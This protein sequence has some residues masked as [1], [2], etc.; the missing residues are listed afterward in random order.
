MASVQT[1][2]GSRD[3]GDLGTT[4]L[5]EHVF[6]RDRELEL[7]PARSEWSEA[8][9]IERAVTGFAALHALGVRTIVDLTVPGLGRDV[10][11]VSAV[12]RR[13]PV[14]LVAS[15]GFYI[16]SELPLYYQFHGPG[17]PI[18]SP[19]PLVE[20][21]VRDIEA[22]ID[23]TTIRAAMLKVVTDVAGMTDDVARVMT[24]AAVAHQQTGV[25]ITTHSHAASRNG[26]AQQAFLR[27]HGVPLERVIIG[28]S[29]DSEDLAYLRRL[30]DD[31]S[32]IGMDR[33]GM[34]HVLP[35]DRRARIV[36]ALLR[37]G[38]G[39]RMVL[40]HDA[41]WFSHVT[42]PSWRA[43]A[44]PRWHME[45]IPRRILPMLRD[46]GASEADLH[47]MLVLNPSRLLEPSTHGAG[48]APASPVPEDHDH[49]RE[50]AT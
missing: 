10:R 30:M 48:A 50:V 17:R 26:L 25:P 40:S 21:F 32:T 42:P 18:D 13:V 45:N 39:D 47:Q 29:G 27:A 7:D 36:L 4:L 16:R 11:V 33:F 12:A 24:A 9:A 8:E 41:A 22:G 6:V 14:N 23:G 28:H 46:G 2:L 49:S 34:E 31:G 1:F 38:Y 43:R 5:H 37:L 44:A 19:D 35:D 3:P 15:T 20:L